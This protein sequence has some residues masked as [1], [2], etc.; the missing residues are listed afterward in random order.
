MHGPAPFWFGKEVAWPYGLAA[1]GRGPLRGGIPGPALPGPF[2]ESLSPASVLTAVRREV[3]V[4]GQAISK[5][6]ILC[7]EK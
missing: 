6:D 7:E 2:G 4:K 3:G 1:E 5:A